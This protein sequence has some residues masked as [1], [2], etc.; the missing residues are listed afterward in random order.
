MITFS[1]N[2][3]NHFVGL[4][5]HDF[6]PPFPI[7]P[8][9]PFLPHFEGG[10]T[11]QLLTSGCISTNVL[12]NGQFAVQLDH[13][14][15]PLVPHIP[16]PLLPPN[17]RLPLHL[18]FSSAKVT[19]CRSNVMVNGVPAG[20]HDM[21]A[22]L[23]LCGQPINLPTGLIIDTWRNTVV[24]TSTPADVAAGWQR[25][26]E[27][28]ALSYVAGKVLKAFGKLFQ[29]VGKM[30]AAEIGWVKRSGEWL[31]KKARSSRWPLWYLTTEKGKTLA[32][33]YVA[34][35]ESLVGKAME[36]AAK[37]FVVKPY[38]K[39]SLKEA[40]QAMAYLE[41]IPM[42]GRPMPLPPPQGKKP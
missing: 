16:I 22:P 39:D 17:L 10:V 23:L 8:I 21:G 11:M 3:G 34:K 9:P 7:P 37:K 27:D 4:S 14:V 19:F 12:F 42:V 26:L 38:L 31:A 41:K 6:V 2:A 25:T 29:W 15:G 13:D 32:P 24:F 18:A 40:K 1:I 35:F 5:L 28:I 36:K 33:S 20:N 30:T